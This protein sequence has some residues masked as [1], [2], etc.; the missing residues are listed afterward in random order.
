MF[1]M[2][3]Y[4]PN[5][6]AGSY[7]KWILIFIY[8]FD[9]RLRHFGSSSGQKFRLHAALAPQH[10]LTQFNTNW[11]KYEVSDQTNLTD[12]VHTNKKINFD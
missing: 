9:I 3:E 7:T 10:C 4:Q 8:Y 2:K 12:F 5:S 11:R 6:H 1:F